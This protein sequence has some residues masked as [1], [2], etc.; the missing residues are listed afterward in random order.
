[1]TRL[2]LKLRSLYMGPGLNANVDVWVTVDGTFEITI[3]EEVF[4]GPDYAEVVR[5]AQAHLHDLDQIEWR[6]VIRVTPEGVTDPDEAVRLLAE[7]ITPQNIPSSVGLVLQRFYV[8]TVPDR[9]V[10]L[11]LPWDEFKGCVSPG[12][13]VVASQ[14]YTGRVPEDRSPWRDG[15][16]MVRDPEAVM[17][18]DE[19][20]WERLSALAD[21]IRLLRLRVSALFAQDGAHVTALE[22]RL[23]G[24]APLI[25]QD[26]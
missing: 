21:Q 17:P 2:R 6:P 26:A 20:T 5:S 16:F 18:Y 8:G 12:D 23:T 11:F 4:K 14:R 7:S 24:G 22:G 25:G 10:K 19:A 1:M 13:K 9:P 3:G 15:K